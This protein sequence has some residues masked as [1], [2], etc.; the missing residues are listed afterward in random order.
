MHRSVGN[1]RTNIL[2]QSMELINLYLC[3]E[4]CKFKQWSDH[5]QNLVVK[6]LNYN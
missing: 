3:L 2:K 1:K 4:T 5:V 6:Q